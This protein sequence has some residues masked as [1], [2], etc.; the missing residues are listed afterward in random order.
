[1]ENVIQES[2]YKTNPNFL[3]RKVANEYLL[4]AVGDTE[5]S[6]S[7]IMILNETGSFIWNHLQKFSTLTEL[8]Q[9][10]KS[11]FED[12]DG[13][14]EQQISEFITSMIKLGLIEEGRV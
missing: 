12:I 10:A 1:M 7:T 6:S 14:L 9:K 4:V 3:M 5:F 11:E 13:V 2:E 8:I